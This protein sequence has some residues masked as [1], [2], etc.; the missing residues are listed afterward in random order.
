MPQTAASEPSQTAPARHFLRLTDLSAAQLGGLLAQAQ[1]HFDCH[2][3]RRG[4]GQAGQRLDAG[5]LDG[6]SILLLFEKSSTRTRL[7]F[8]L[9][10]RELGGTPVYMSTQ[11]SQVG[12]GESAGDTAKVVSSMVD[13]VIMRTGAHERILEFARHSRVGVIN[14]LTQS[15]HPCQVLADLLTVQQA[16]GL[17]HSQ[18][19]EMCVAWVGDGNNMCQSWMDA[20]DLLGFELRVACP[21]GYEPQRAAGPSV[22]L[23]ADPA[24]AVR[25]AQVVNTDVWTSMGDEAEEQQRRRDLQPYRVDAALLAGAAKDP[26]LLHCLPAHW[27]EEL[28]EGLRD[29][30]LSRWIWRQA[31]NRLHSSKAL[32]QA[33]FAP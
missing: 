5:A 1:C 15:D 32:L 2:R 27:G 3:S 23:C 7:S 9:A 12:R 25:G 29:S 30:E 8:E 28:D 24:E 13:G 17:D 26:V 16:R 33:F 14:A 20:A 6:R 10:V 4:G 11:D 31:E 18:L 22:R 19:G 21:P